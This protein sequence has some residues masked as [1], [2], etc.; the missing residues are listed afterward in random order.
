MV[1]A[2]PPAPVVR[3]DQREDDGEQPRREGRE[4]REVELGRRGLVAR[5]VSRP[6]GDRDARGAD[7]QVDPEDQPPIDVDQHAPD[8]RPDRERERRDRR[9]DAE[10][11]ALLLDRERVAD[12]RQGERQHRR[13]ARPLDHAR[14]DQHQVVTGHGRKHRAGREDR[15]P[16]QED[17]APAVDVAEPPRR[18]HQ[19]ADHQQ[20]AVQHPLHVVAGGVQLLLDGRQRESD[21]GGVEHQ[22]EQ[23]QARADE[24]PPAPPG[25]GG[26][27]HS[28]DGSSSTAI[29]PGQRMT[30]PGGTARRSSI[31]RPSAS[32]KIRSSGNRIPK[33]WTL[34]QRGIS[35]P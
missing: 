14:R 21:H 24:H 4:A 22:D 8:E 18:H 26:R 30:R 25:F 27:G 11:L 7:R 6:A 2:G 15:H 20:V 5:L 29:A 31:T 16:D 13:A 34:R 10:G 33:V 17:Q 9:P 23:P 28:G 32:R 3:A 35:R 1:L 19:D 12:D